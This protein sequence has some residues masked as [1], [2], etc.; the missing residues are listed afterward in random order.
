MISSQLRSIILSSNKTSQQK[1]RN[2]RRGPA[3]TFQISTKKAVLRISPTKTDV[4]VHFLRKIE[5]SGN[6]KKSCQKQK[7]NKTK[8]KR[9]W[10]L[11]TN[12]NNQL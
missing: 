7:Q 9:D 3:L 5:S 2:E 8:Q 11:I 12:I 10:I 6:H 4:S 1:T